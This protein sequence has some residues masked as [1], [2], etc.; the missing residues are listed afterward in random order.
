M[1]RGALRASLVLASWSVAAGSALAAGPTVTINQA[2]A[3]ADPTNASPILFTVVFSTPVQG[4]AT[5]DVSLAGSTVGGTLV[6]T[7]SGSNADYTVSVTGMTGTG[8][9]VASIPACARTSLSSLTRPRRA[10]T[11]R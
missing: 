10:P 11:T 7:V 2:A 6:A 4:F 3:Q 8:A 1:Y 5:G 9:V